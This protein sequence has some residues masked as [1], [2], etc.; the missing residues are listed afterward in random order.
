MPHS[1]NKDDGAWSMINAGRL[2]ESRFYEGVQTAKHTSN[3][4][5]ER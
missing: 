5:D 4:V 1:I 2:L 3:P